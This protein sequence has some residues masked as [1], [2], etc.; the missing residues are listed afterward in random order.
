MSLAAQGALFSLRGPATDGRL[1]GDDSVGFDVQVFDG[2]GF[3]DVGGAA[4]RGQLFADGS[5]GVIAATT[6]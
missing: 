2:V 5:A 1:A 4:A 6:A 3:A